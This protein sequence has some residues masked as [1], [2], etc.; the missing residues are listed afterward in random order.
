[1]LRHWPRRESTAGAAPVESGYPVDTAGWLRAELDGHPLEWVRSGT[2][3]VDATYGKVGHTT[4]LTLHTRG[5]PRPGGGA[6][7][8]PDPH[9]P[10][11]IV[12]PHIAAG[13]PVAEVAR[14]L[15]AKCLD[16]QYASRSADAPPGTVSSVVIP[17]T[18]RAGDVA[19]L[20]SDGS[21]ARR[22]VWVHPLSPA[23]MIVAR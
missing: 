2:V 10:R 3:R 18:A 11:R 12:L 16:V 22:T 4:R 15:R 20:P 21:P 1:M 8:T 5:R 13:A 23:T 17:T 7:C 9:R 14:R 6:T 19:I